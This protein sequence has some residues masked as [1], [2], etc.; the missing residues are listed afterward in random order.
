MSVGSITGI[1]STVWVIRFAVSV[2]L[3]APG[4]CGGSADSAR[5]DAVQGVAPQESVA[6]SWRIG[7]RPRIEIGSVSDSEFALYG[8][9]GASFL[10]DGRIVVGNGGTSE[11][12]LF[13]P[14]GRLQGAVGRRGAGPGEFLQMGAIG[15]GN[16]DTVFVYDRWNARI[17]VFDA[18]GELARTGVVDAGS[19]IPQAMRQAIR[20][21]PS[22][23][24]AG[25]TT[26]GV[27]VAWRS[28][29]ELDGLELAGSPSPI[30][31]QPL[32]SIRHSRPIAEL[33]F[34]DSEGRVIG[35][36][37]DLPGSE[38]LSFSRTE[39]HRT[40]GGSGA[41]S[42]TSTQLD[43][44][45][46]KTLEVTAAWDVV[47]FGNTARYE[48][49]LVHPDGRAIATMRRPMDTGEVTVRD[50]DRWIESQ[51]VKIE[52][53]ELRSRR[54][55][56]YETIDFPST[57]PAFRSLAIQEGGRVWVE[58][59][60][61]PTDVPMPSTWQIYDRRGLHLGQAVLPAGFRPTSI[62]SD[63]VIGVWKDELDVEYIRVYALEG[64]L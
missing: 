20:A 60:R 22:L 27:L 31:P 53:V 3:L 8:V 44:P 16:T 42:S 54:R 1:P 26:T 43:V 41:V 61:V 58:E 25:W 47:A 56:L 48:I 39:D 37:N 52:D 50:R 6:S 10:S 46:L 18:S 29:L 14:D 55:V 49:R 9:V 23:S 34:V 33:L 51:L 35:A 30:A 11:L 40:A 32:E 59:F 38:S 21:G 63:Q 28:I 2:L 24:P 5:D 13:G 62:S 45:F 57:M 19:P 12:L 64:I 17:S 15:V 4:S 36:V 7:P